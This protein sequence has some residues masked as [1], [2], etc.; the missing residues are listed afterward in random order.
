MED[1]ELVRDAAA[2]LALSAG[3]ARAARLF[4]AATR[5]A[6]RGGADDLTLARRLLAQAADDGSPYAAVELALMEL[7]G[8]GGPADPAAALA[9]LAVAAEA[10]LP[11]AQLLLGGALL[12]DGVRAADGVAWLRR[13]A[14]AGEWSASWLLGTA[15]LRGLGVAREPAQARVMMQLAAQQGVVEAQLELATLYAG[16]VGGRRDD[17]AAAR[18]ELAAAE[19]GHP[20]GCLRVGERALAQPGGVARAIPW[21]ERAAAGGSAA[22]AERLARLYSDGAELPPDAARAAE[23]RA[24]AAALSSRRD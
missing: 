11:A 8:R 7:G 18:W 22:A 24:R 20:L 5:L 12:V 14:A 4:V 19:A 2:A 16:G 17:A 9:R 3:E 6:A 21:L 15:Y 23:W 10:G 1:D 13:A